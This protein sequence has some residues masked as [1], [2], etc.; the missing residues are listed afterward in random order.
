MNVKAPNPLR[1]ATRKWWNDIMATFELE[2]H[3]IR[4]LVLACESWGSYQQARESLRKNGLTFLNRA[5]NP[6]SRP[7]VAIERDSRM[8]FCRVL[9][10]LGLDGAGSPETPRLP[11][12]PPLRAN[13]RPSHGR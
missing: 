10:E 4:L 11:P 3:Q 2:P 1:A 8:A 6:A 13:R 7:E 5:G 12:P 9:R